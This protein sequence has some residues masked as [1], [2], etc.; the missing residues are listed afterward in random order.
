MTINLTQAYQQWMTRSADEAFRSLDDLFAFTSSRKDNSSQSIR[1]LHD[2]HTEATTSG[3][4]VLNGSERPAALTHWSLGQLAY[5]IGAPASYLRSLSP[6]LARDCLQY[7]LNN[8]N[9]SCNTLYRIEANGSGNSAPVA[10]A[11]TGPAYGRIWDADVVEQLVEAT[12]GSSWKIPANLSDA[13]NSRGSGLYASDRDMFAFMV[14]EE[15]AVDVGGAK[16]GRGFF[17]WNS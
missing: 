4:L 5:H 11:F 15:D 10:A 13:H 8:S 14:N 9:R 17:C 12:D 6:E 16:L 7:G 1:R 2:L 3:S